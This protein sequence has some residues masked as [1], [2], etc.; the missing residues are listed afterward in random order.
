MIKVPEHKDA[1]FVV[2]AA[3]AAVVVNSSWLASAAR[4]AKCFFIFVCLLEVPR[5]KWSGIILPSLAYVLQ[6][7]SH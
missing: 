3:T 7:L 2:A 1:L 5:W 6:I 4:V